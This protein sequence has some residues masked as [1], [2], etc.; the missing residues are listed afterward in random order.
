MSDQPI[1]ISNALPAR[2][3]MQYEYLR[4]LGINRAQ[5]LAGQIWTDFNAHDPGVT[6]LEVF[7]YAIT[8]LGYRVSYDIKDLIANNPD[9]PNAIDIKNFYTA[10]QIMTNCP[11]TFTDYRKLL[12]DVEVHA[13]GTD[14]EY[15]GVRNAWISK[16]PGPECD[17]YV[18]RNTNELSYEPDPVLNED[19]QTLLDIK[20]LYDVLLEFD[21]CDKF[22]DLNANTLERRYTVFDYDP[23]IYEGLKLDITVEFPRWD[24]EL[25]DWNDPI[26]I[27]HRVRDIRVIFSGEP[28]GTAFTSSV[29]P[30]KDLVITGN[31]GTEAELVDLNIAVNQFI[32]EG[33]NSMLAAYQ[34]KV[35]K[36]QEIITAARARMMANR[37]LC[38]DLFRFRAIKIEEIAICSDIEV[39]PDA[40]IEEVQAAMLT[41]IQDYLSPTVYFYSL[42][43][44]VERGKVTEDI[45]EGPQLEHGFIDDDELNS[46]DLRRYVHASDLIQIIMDIP[47]V[48]K[49]RSLQIANNLLDNDDELPTKSVKWCLKLAVDSGYVPRINIDNSQVIFFKENLPFTANTDEVDTLVEEIVSTARQ[50]KQRGISLD[51]EIP[52]GEYKSLEDYETVQN[53]FPLVY[54]IGEEG[55]GA[56]E[57]QA[58]K[59]QAKQM[60]G[61]LMFFDQMMANYL[62]QVAHVKDLF[63]MNGEVDGNDNFIIDRS[64]FTQ[65]LFNN[66]PNVD[67]LYVDKPGHAD[68]LTRIAETEALFFDRRNRFLDHLM[69]RFAESFTEYALL[70]FQL[71]GKKDSLE[72]IKDKLNFLDKYPAI[73][74]SRGKAFNYESP[75]DLWSVDNHSGLNQRASLLSGIDDWPISRL[76]FSPNFEIIDTGS[77]FTFNINNE[78]NTSVLTSPSGV[79]FETEDDVKYALERVLINGVCKERYDIFQET[80]SG[81]TFTLG[82]DG[83]VL[84]EGVQQFVD[85]VTASAG[86]DAVMNTL[87]EEFYGNPESNRKNLACPLLNYWDCQVTNLDTGGT[88]PTYTVELSLFPTPFDFSDPN[89]A[90]LTG[91]FDAEG[92]ERIAADIKSVDGTNNTFLVQG[93]VIANLS[94]GDIIYVENSDDYDTTGGYEVV[95]VTLDGNNKTAIQVVEDI[96]DPTGTNLGQVLIN[97][98]TNE[99]INSFAKEQAKDQIWKILVNGLRRDRYQYNPSTAPYTDYRFEIINS[100]CEVLATSVGADFNQSVANQFTVNKNFQV[101]TAD[102]VPQTFDYTVMSS[103][104]DGPNVI[105]EVNENMNPL[106]SSALGGTLSFS[107]S[108]GFTVDKS[109]RTFTIP[110]QTLTGKLR[111]GDSF[112]I[113][114]TPSNDNIYTIASISLSGSDT[115]IVSKES[116]AVNQ[117]TVGTGTFNF[118]KSWTINRVVDETGAFGFSITGLG[119][120]LAVSD[121][122]EFI[123][124]KFFSHEGMHV[125]ENILL[126]PKHKLTKTVELAD[127]AL[128]DDDQGIADFK[129]QMPVTKYNKED[130]LICVSTNVALLMLGVD[131]IE[132]TDSIHNNGVYNINKSA[133]AEFGIIYNAETNETCIEVIE[134]LDTDCLIDGYLCFEKPLEVAS[135]S[136][137]GNQVSFRENSRAFIPENFVDIL[138]EF[139][140]EKVFQKE[141]T[142]NYT[143]NE[144]LTNIKSVTRSE[145]YPNTEA[146]NPTAE[147]KVTQDKV[148]KKADV[149]ISM[150]DDKGFD[151]NIS[152]SCDNITEDLSKV[153]RFDGVLVRE[154]TDEKATFQVMAIIESDEG[155]RQAF[156]FIG[157]TDIRMVQSSSDLL[158][159]GAKFKLSGTFD[160]LNDG[161]YVV[162]TVSS[163]DILPT[164]GVSQKEDIIRPNL[165]PIDL[166]NTCQGCR[167]E[168]P[169]TCII[170]VIVPYWAGRVLDTDFREFLERRIRLETPSHIVV[171]VCFI[172]CDMM[173]E[174]E[175]KYKAFLVE[176]SKVVKDVEQL[177]KALNELIDILGRVRNFY[178]KGT[179][180][181][182][183]EDE[184][185]IDSIILSNSALGTA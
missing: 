169:Y 140:N 160:G 109:T 163:F 142:D 93:N 30:T 185:T 34:E 65:T 73:S 8:D 56:S 22:G 64:Y 148:S 86:V 151:C 69:A 164:V 52:T 176:N 2:L 114:G 119:D 150:K 35:Q 6:M 121:M 61:F 125:I 42:E 32:Y 171:N 15:A 51:F 84:A 1:T 63:S 103:T 175:L 49:V 97:E 9:D 18:H 91:S 167:V 13:P 162:G 168:D 25:V 98:P 141:A 77:G 53:D 145:F 67:E 47:G 14:C 123:N 172:D 161:S 107:E 12:M 50:Q 108:H 177:T 138:N 68:A 157:E 136:S 45:F 102:Q 11:V 113:S 116:V 81:F 158:K 118:T 180:H 76:N 29:D 31:P 43:E 144:P 20:V 60:K 44:M 182:C 152:L 57:T 75:C 78:S 135:I 80:G 174:F 127:G 74:A 21:K 82:C 48:R 156:R 133:D 4:D 181:D 153:S 106:P 143:V 83:E 128:F 37:N 146:D 95:S 178:P 28:D 115:I 5:Q 3:S 184:D 170:S 92:P 130:S 147:V 66:V 59:N 105:I 100:R 58:R 124:D 139:N 36:V 131:T 24:D 120:E 71:D 179:L 137:D 94:P 129:V 89:T 87:G 19:D 41:A 72:L 85:T 46:A 166:N 33:V 155:S 126:R 54:G 112:S 165:L 96:V 159:P 149:N 39:T 104:A 16:A 40:D 62:S 183:L 134:P 117:D 26:T 101:V 154:T 132:I 110:G 23:E 79:L 90:L 173:E 122:I 38:E 27:R 55:L 7:S 111:V 17:I 70:Q 88:V 10:R 99:I